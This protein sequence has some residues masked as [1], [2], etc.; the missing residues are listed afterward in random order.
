MTQGIDS[1]LSVA[2]GT[3]TPVLSTCSHTTWVFTLNSKS[4]ELIL[5]VT[6]IG[7]TPGI[8]DEVAVTTTS[9][10]TVESTFFVIL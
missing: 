2:I 10:A 8:G 5:D 7:S 9:T 3:P 4:N 6:E 1:L